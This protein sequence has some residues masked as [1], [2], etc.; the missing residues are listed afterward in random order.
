MTNLVPI[1]VDAWSS[2]GTVRIIDTLVVDTTCLPIAHAHPPHDGTSF[3]LSSLSAES[4]SDGSNQ[5][6]LASLI[7]SNAAH[8]AEQMIADAEVYGAMRSNTRTFMGGRLDLLGDVKLRQELEKQ[9]G[10]QLNIAMSAGKKS[11]VSDTRSPFTPDGALSSGDGAAGKHKQ[12]ASSLIR[13]KLR[14]RHENIVVFDEFMYDVRTSGMEGC[15]PFS[16]S[17]GIVGDLKLP[18]ELAPTIAASI[19]EQIYGVDVSSSQGAVQNNPSALV[20]DAMK[21]GTPS[22]FAQIMLDK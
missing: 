21:E 18:P 2:D 19:V 12:P 4:R 16:I 15:D 14:L 7:E 10:M 9:I 8:L 22:D 6:S 13:I 11:L 17:K 20:L 1:R 3:G 5:F